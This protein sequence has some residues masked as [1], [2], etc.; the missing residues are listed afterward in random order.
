VPFPAIR[1]ARRRGALLRAAAAALALLAP[2]A[3][4]GG[5]HDARV[6]SLAGDLY[7][8]EGES[9]LLHMPRCLRAAD[10]APATIDLDKKAVWIEGSP[11]ACA[12]HRLLR[13]VQ[14]ALGL[15]DLRLTSRFADIYEAEIH[16][17][18]FL[19]EDCPAPAQDAPSKA[20]IDGRADRLLIPAPD[21]PAASVTGRVTCP[22]VAVLT[23]LAF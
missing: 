21:N 10:R 4:A 7:A 19:T 6:T 12:I 23:E 9:V 17:W 5:L 13:P 15:Y 18:M 16:G 14:A 8:V 1:P 2:P 3:A 20:V 22:I 11:G